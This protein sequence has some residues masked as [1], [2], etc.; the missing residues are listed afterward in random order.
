M[1]PGTLTID[2]QEESDGIAVL[3]LKGV[4]DAHTYKQ[5]AEVLDK[6]LEKLCFKIVLDLSA[7]EYLSSSGVGVISK[8]FSTIKA[9]N[10]NLVLMNPTQHVD[11]VLSLVG[12]P[13]VL[14]IVQDL[15]AAISVFKGRRRSKG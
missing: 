15:P 5:F 7:L 4:L 8:S 6:L 13:D 1:M 14:P 12:L 11:Q 9:R 3:H 10:G 2:T